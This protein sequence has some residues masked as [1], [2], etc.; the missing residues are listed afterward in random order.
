MQREVYAFREERVWLRVP[1]GHG[2]C[3]PMSEFDS[4]MV[5]VEVGGS[6]KF[7]RF[8]PEERWCIVAGVWSLAAKSPVRGYLLIADSV[9]VEVA[10]VAAQAEVKPTVAKK[11]LEKMRRL[12]MLESDEEIGAEHVH[13][14]HLHQKEPKSSETRASWRERQKR[15]RERKREGVTADVT[16]DIRDSVTPESRAVSHPL[17]EEKRRK[18]KR[19]PPDP[20]RGGRVRDREKWEKEFA[21][22]LQAHP[23]TLELLEEWEPLADRLAEVTGEQYVMSR[24]GLLHPHSFTDGVWLLGGPETPTLSMV[25]HFAESSSFKTAVGFD[26]ELVDCGCELSRECA[27]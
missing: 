5:R 21:V 13:D 15:S 3:D 16:R 25:R 7:A 9:P 24:L 2:L 27:A 11:T 10:D 4:I 6:R 23:V 14:W 1:P 22:W 18:G 20:P 26:W 17:R 12:G 19:T 8:S